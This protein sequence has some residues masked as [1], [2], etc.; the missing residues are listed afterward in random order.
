MEPAS[1]PPPRQRALITISAIL[2]TVMVIL[3]TTIANVA[4]PNM[5][6]ALGANRETVTW[7]LTSYIVASAIGTPITGWLA[8][9]IGM[10]QLFMIAIS[11][12]VVASMLCG[13]ATSLPMMVGYRALQGLFGAFL[14]PIT[15]TVLLDAYP[16]E[17]HPQA[18]AIWG[19]AV[20]ASPVLGPV[21]GG[22][23]TDNYSWRWVFYVNMPVGAL[24]LAGAWISLPRS[25][26]R[27]RSF[28]LFGF[29]LVASALAGL[30][31]LLDRGPQL[32][33]FESTEIVLEAG[34]AFCA[35]WMLVVHLIYDKR[36]LFDLALFADRNFVAAL[37][38]MFVVGV[39]VTGG[40]ALLPPMLQQLFGYPTVAAGLL[41]APRGLGTLVGFVAQG[42]LAGRVDPR[43]VML[44]GFSLL[45]VS[46]HGM[47]GFSPQ[48]GARLVVTTGVIQGLGMGLVMGPLFSL[49]YGTMPAR[50]RTDAGSLLNLIRSVGGSVGVAM[51]TA[52]LAHNVQV[53]H[54]DIAAH[55]TLESMPL[56]QV[57]Q[58]AGGAADMAG[59][60]ID[61]E[62]NRQAL[63]IA[64][65]DDYWL[66]MALA[67]LTAPLLL[68]VR[69]PSAAAAGETHVAME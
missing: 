53:S 18:L 65:I 19:A 68:I 26:K 10:K 49:A 15:Q 52:V 16:R 45:A 56:G 50:L 13:A 23:L 7:V 67:V 58:L 63:M 55:I 3:D 5:Q 37:C 30:Q 43:M 39:V 31:L 28:D 29:A 1:L 12:F 9:R 17:K 41:M 46:L 8:D 21:L 47:T 36:R 11:G 62:I 33:W 24:T 6:A 35:F 4:L 34:I 61:G 57:A 44:T 38:F 42:R 64:Y 14:A 25:R 48:M 27:Q 54:S 22:W 20:M 60:M 2:A 69:R 40:A 32:D 59:A 66:M 51:V